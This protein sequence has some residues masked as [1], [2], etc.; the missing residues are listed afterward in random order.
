MKNAFSPVFAALA[1]FFFLFLPS[2]PCAAGETVEKA[3]KR[4]E[5]GWATMQFSMGLMYE[6]GSDGLGRDPA[7]AVKWFR[8]AAEQ[9]DKESIRIL[10]RHEEPGGPHDPL[11]GIWSGVASTPNGDVAFP[12]IVEV[13][14]DDDTYVGQVTFNGAP[15]PIANCGLY[16]PD[17]R[18]IL[19]SEAVV[20][21][22]E[23]FAIVLDGTVGHDRWT[24]EFFLFDPA[25]RGGEARTVF[26][27]ARTGEA[28]ADLESGM[29]EYVRKLHAKAE[30]GDMYAMFALGSLSFVGQFTMPKS[31]DTALMWFVRSAEKGCSEAMTRLGTLY[32]QGDVVAKDRDKGIVWLRKA[33]AAGDHIA[34]RTL[35]TIH[36]KESEKGEAAPSSP[37]GNPSPAP[38]PAA[39]KKGGISSL[40][41]TDPLSGLWEGSYAEEGGGEPFRLRI[42]TRSTVELLD[43]GVEMRI[44]EAHVKDGLATVRAGWTDDDGMRREGFFA[45]PIRNNGWEGTV[46][47]TG[48]SAV[49]FQ[50]T[51]TLEKK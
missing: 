36:P 31:I 21:S 5:A 47:V 25:R 17:R 46:E 32:L 50:G 6:N 9:G 22:N 44:A 39:A 16:L 13:R 1:A 35:E 20:G 28:W 23:S 45:G 34:R 48:G 3:L 51:F 40:A 41:K 7:E 27:L 37:S 12:L 29:G 18:G 49:L 10:E 43:E 4:A 14:V 19:E 11:V 8:R 38:R 2:P 26:R 15:V 42:D 24:G 30:K 33:A